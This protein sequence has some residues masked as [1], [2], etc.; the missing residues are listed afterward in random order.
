[1]VFTPYMN[2]VRSV[3]GTVIAHTDNADQEANARLIAAA[4][5]VLEALRAAAGY[6][7]N[8][9]ID[10]ETGAP[11]RTAIS[12]IEGGLAVVRAAIAKAEGTE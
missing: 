11:K 12:T 10:L 5:E 2:C 1:L 6:L 7:L 4:P 3:S 9:K 8:A